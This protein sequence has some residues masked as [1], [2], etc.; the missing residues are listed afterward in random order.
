MCGGGNRAHKVTLCTQNKLFLA[1]Q[2]VT[3]PPERSCFA[4]HSAK[5][6]YC[7]HVGISPFYSEAMITSFLLAH[8]VY[9]E[10]QARV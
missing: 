7:S 10:K 1:P 3:V 4:V 6:P 9:K 5:G 2:H 8:L